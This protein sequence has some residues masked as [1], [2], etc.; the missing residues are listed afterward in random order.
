MSKLKY[1]PDNLFWH[2]DRETFDENPFRLSIY[3]FIFFF[4]RLYCYAQKH[5]RS[6]RAVTRTDESQRISCRR[7]G[8]K[9]KF[10]KRSPHQLTGYHTSGFVFIFLFVA[11]ANLL[12]IFAW[13]TI[14]FS[15]QIVKQPLQ[16]A[17]LW[18]YFWVRLMTY[19][20]ILKYEINSETCLCAFVVIIHKLNWALISL[21]WGFPCAIYNIFVWQCATY[22]SYYWNRIH[23]RWEWQ[24]A[25]LKPH[26]KKISEILLY[27]Y[28][29]HLVFIFN[30]LL[31]AIFLYQYCGGILQDVHWRDDI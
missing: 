3:L 16:W 10:C 15:L 4:V 28:Q 30:S 31:D 7:N 26:I 5:V 18:V 11:D 23:Q 14:V 8:G 6:I 17:S 24:N 9:K 29:F 13:L 12:N 25:Q 22:C 19:N 20:H 21:F 1:Y 2:S 27:L